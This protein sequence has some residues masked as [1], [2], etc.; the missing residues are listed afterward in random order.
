[1]LPTWIECSYYIESTSGLESG[2]AELVGEQTS[3]TFIKVPGESDQ[4][5]ECFGGR[6]LSLE[7]FGKVPPSLVT[8]FEVPTV[9][10]G[11]IRVAYPVGN[12]GGDL[13]TLLTTIAG[14]LYE[15]G[16]LTACRLIDIDIPDEFTQHHKGPEFGIQG[17]REAVKVAE[18]PLIGTI[19]KPNIGL[20]E[21]GFR[22]IIRTLLDSGLDFIKDD[23]INADPA[24]LPFERRVAI[25]S[26]ETERAADESGRKIPYAFNV[27]GP[28]KDLERKHDL[29]LNSG[30]QCVMLPVFYQGISALEYLRDLG[31]LQLHAHRAGF[32]AVSR[33]GSLGIDFKVWQKLLQLAGADHIHASG[34]QSKFFETDD[35]VATNI[36]AIQSGVSEKFRSSLPILS[37][38]Q[39][40]FAAQPT[41]DKVGSTDVMMLAGGGII[42][43]P[44]GAAAG[45]R[46]LRQSWEAAATEQALTD[47]GQ[48]LA[49]AGDFAV[50]RAVEKFGAMR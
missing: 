27:A 14:N 37:S 44:L 21:E 10:A 16:H 28:F 38:G 30:G 4:L 45:V 5:A 23:E 1:M 2:A 26:E 19:V 22:S 31:G 8:R 50:A 18:G 32:A 11:L 24:H 34:L 47:F 15:L 29:V 20:D 40:V 42:G 13:T 17:T 48:Q 43:H 36:K 39:T 3:G 41:M 7:S 35:E 9:D 33:S 46:S 25:V 12:F 6:V 49:D